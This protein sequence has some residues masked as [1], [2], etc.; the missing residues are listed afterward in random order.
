MTTFSPAIVV[1]LDI[2]Y[3]LHSVLRVYAA[4]IRLERSPLSW[5]SILSNNDDEGVLFVTDY[6]QLSNSG[7]F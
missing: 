6:A 7:V 1:V 3:I 5:L 2:L 4:N